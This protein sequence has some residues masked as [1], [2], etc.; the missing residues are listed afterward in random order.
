MN[1]GTRV[2]NAV[3]NVSIATVM[4][5]ITIIIS[6]VSRTVFVKLLGNDY[7]SCDGLFTNVLTILSFSELGIGSAIIYSLYKPISENNKKQIGKLMHLY[8]D[9]YKYIICSILIF[10]IALIPLLPNLISNVPN[11]KE[12]LIL[13]YILFLCDTIASYFLGYKKTFLI[14]NQENYIVLLVQ[15]GLKIV[16]IIFQILLLFVTHNYILY[17]IISIIFTL[18]SNI[19]CNFIV[20]HKYPWIDNYMKYRLSKKEKKTVF[21][22]IKSIVY[23]KFG[24]VILGGTDNILISA[25]L[26]TSYVG[27]CSN[28]NLIIN[29]AIGVIN[30]GLNGMQATVGNYNVTFN[31]K[32]REDIFNQLY[33]IS[34]WIFSFCFIALVV[35]ITPFVRIWLGESYTLSSDVTIALAVSFY[36]LLINSVPSMYRSSLGLFKETKFIPFYSAIINIVLSI[37]LAKFI[38]LSGIF[39]ATSIS[40]LLTF[41]I[42]DPYYVYKK[43][44]EGSAVVFYKKSISYFILTVLNCLIA[45]YL[46]SIISINGIIGFLLKAIVLTIS[47]NLIFYIFFRKTTY[48]KKSI[49]I[50]N[51]FIKKKLKKS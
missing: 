15:Q 46:V 37:V 51:D 19:V 45:F 3:K 12:S 42:F 36:I 34:Y 27:I 8:K 14:A 43:G 41:N 17:L 20:N 49:K 44:F 35:L 16:R 1:S 10:G 24:S 9:A 21:D 38:G 39:F 30:Q 26:K 6:F 48:Y 11:V 25:I 28:Y 5:V 18:I 13:L 7:L 4:Q 47:S 40:R 32:S 31:K 23:Y 33:F 22:N 29:T 50:L 2:K